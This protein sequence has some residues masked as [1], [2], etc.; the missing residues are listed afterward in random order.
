MSDNKNLWI[1]LESVFLVVFLIC[2]FVLSGIRHNA[3][4]WI[5]FGSIILAYFALL[6]T[7]SFV[8]SGSVETDYRRPLFVAGAIYFLVA[9]G[10]N[11]YVLFDHP[12]EYQT[13]LI[14][15]VVL[16]GIYIVV[17]VANMLANDNT[18]HQQLRREGE[19]R[20]VKDVPARL[21][22]VAGGLLDPSLSRKLRDVADIVA[23]S[24]ARSSA[25]VASIEYRILEELEKLEHR[26]IDDEGQILL[27]A[28]LIAA[29]TRN[30]NTILKSGN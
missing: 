13:T 26:Q 19:L 29:L 2:F 12:V 21:R 8:R 3:A 9:F 22:M 11:L 25:S 24:P 15:N 18:A 7:P 30:R 23:L 16:L 5:A 28:E 6:A 27:S 4:E 14:V 17:L 1:I 10:Y 20:F